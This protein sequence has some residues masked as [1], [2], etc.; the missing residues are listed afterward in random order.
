MMEKAHALVNVRDINLICH[1]YKTY[2][3][4]EG[5]VRRRKITR[6]HRRNGVLQGQNSSSGRMDAVR[7]MDRVGQ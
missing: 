7:R 4:I 6:A 5:R 1:N 3:Q 2:A